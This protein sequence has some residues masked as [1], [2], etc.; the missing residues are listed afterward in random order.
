MQ[1]IIIIYLYIHHNDYIDFLNSNYQQKILKFNNSLNIFNGSVVHIPMIILIIFFINNIAAKILYIV[2]NFIYTFYQTLIYYRIMHKFTNQ[3][4]MEQDSDGS[5]DDNDDTKVKQRYFMNP[6][7]SSVLMSFCIILDGVY[8][9][10]CKE[11]GIV[12]FM[13]LS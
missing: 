13:S 5:D 6:I 12:L 1:S 3:V 7:F 8:K 2:F 11:A 9:T 4:L 10:E